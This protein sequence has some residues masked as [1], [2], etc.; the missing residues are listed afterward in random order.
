MQEMYGSPSL[1]L[2]TIPG[3]ICRIIDGASLLR[4]NFGGIKKIRRWNK[5]CLVK[6]LNG[7]PIE[8]DYLIVDDGKVVSPS[9]SYAL[10]KILQFP[11]TATVSIFIS[12]LF[13][14]KEI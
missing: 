2:Q 10:K 3:E 12:R 14:V 5:N 13:C 9:Y 8:L 6:F 11:I 4:Y 7:Q 1:P